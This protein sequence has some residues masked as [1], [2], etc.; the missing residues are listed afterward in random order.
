MVNGKSDSIGVSGLECSNEDW[1]GSTHGSISAISPGGH[2]GSQRRDSG[3]GG[4]GPV[5]EVEGFS[6]GFLV[7]GVPGVLSHVSVERGLVGSPKVLLLL[8]RAGSGV[9]RFGSVVFT[10]GGG[11]GS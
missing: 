7:I 1:V 2:L 5:S 8:D 3:I 11:G 6:G 10:R 4:T 9:G